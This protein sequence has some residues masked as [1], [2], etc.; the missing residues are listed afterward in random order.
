MWVTDGTVEGTKRVK[1]ELWLSQADFTVFGDRAMFSAVSNN[2]G[3]ELWVTDGTETGTTLVKDI[4]PGAPWSNPRFMTVFGDHVFF[5]GDDGEHSAELWV[6]DGTET[7]TMLVKDINPG[8]AWSNPKGFTVLHDQLLFAADDGVHGREL[9]SL[10]PIKPAYVGSIAQA[11]TLEEIV[12]ATDYK[13]DTHAEIL[14]L[15]PAFFGRQ[16][17]VPGA[18]YWINDVYENAGRS[19]TEIA[20]YFAND[21]LS[22]FHDTYKDIPPNDHEAY[23]TRIY[24]NML[25]RGPD[26]GGF[27]YWLALMDAG[28]LDRGGVVRW[29]ALNTEFINR[30]PYRP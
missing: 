19:T 27:D 9:W 23:L 24:R 1:K 3:R 25:A 10:K 12:A 13:P 29:V 4:N 5:N 8:A 2:L 7:G 21:L 15:Y 11:T 18:K 16:A 14:R 26:P 17:D 30:Y 20:T 22:E 6:T 28:V